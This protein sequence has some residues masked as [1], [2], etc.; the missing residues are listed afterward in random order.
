MSERERERALKEGAGVGVC[1]R[2]R[3][4]AEKGAYMGLHPR[5]LRL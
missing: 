4:S 5:T 3:L 1:G 2:N